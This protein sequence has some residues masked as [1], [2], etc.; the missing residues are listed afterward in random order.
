MHT[1]KPIAYGMSS[2]T[3]KHQSSPEPHGKIDMLLPGICT[4]AHKPIFGGSLLELLSQSPHVFAV[5]LSGSLDSVMSILIK[6][7]RLSTH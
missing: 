5:Y 3:C 4:T 1:G 2:E 7:T 6:S